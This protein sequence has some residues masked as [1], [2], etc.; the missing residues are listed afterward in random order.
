MKT[1]VATILSIVGVL[2]AGS[3][4]A[5]VN[6]QILDGAGSESAASAAVLPPPAT[7]DLTVP[8]TAV[9]PDQDRF[10][11]DRFDDDR[12][13]TTTS[14]SVAATT[15]TTSPASTDRDQLTAF[16]VGDSGVVTV[17]VVNSELILVNTEARAGWTVTKAEEHRPD[18][19][20]VTFRSSTV[21]VDFEA[22]FDGT[23][24]S[25]SVSSAAIPTA[26]PAPA[27]PTPTD[28]VRHDDDHHDDDDEDEEDDYDDHDEVDEEDDHDEVD[29]EDEDHHEDEEDEEDEDRD[30]D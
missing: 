25:P 29:E 24:I 12:A 6:T 1:R 2:A 30:D 21:R 18:R 16:S 5:L 28:T 19:V 3:A 11:E 27:T 20:E 22:T 26:G 15:T 17:D 9:G 13:S 4:A 14:T 8:S 7:V 23:S 10:D